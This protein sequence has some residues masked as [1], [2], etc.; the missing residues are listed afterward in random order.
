MTERGIDVVKTLNAGDVPKLRNEALLNELV[1]YTD[2]SWCK[3]CQRVEEVIT[4]LN[5]GERLTKASP[6]GP[7][8]LRDGCKSIPYLFHKGLQK[9]MP[10]SET[11]KS[12]LRRKFDPRP[13]YV[14]ADEPYI[15]GEKQEDGFTVTPKNV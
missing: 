10:G 11:I 5:L 14:A 6:D 7:E 4:E 12:Y 3:P 1:L 9:G 15:K 13:E 2:P 8:A